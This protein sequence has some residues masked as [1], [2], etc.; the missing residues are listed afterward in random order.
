MITLR[1]LRYLQALAQHRH[2]GRAASACAVTQPALSMQ[3][4]DLER[5]LGATLV[6]RG[7]GE[8]KLTEIGEEI[9]RRSLRILSAV[10][11]LTEYALHRGRI[12]CG[13][14][15]LGVIPTLA[16]YLLPRILPPL[17]A[18]YPELRLELRE[19]QT[20]SLIA[21][22]ARGGL[23]AVVMA[24]PVED[25]DFETTALFEDRF[26]LAAPAAEG[27]PRRARIEAS[28]IDPRRLILLEDGHCLRDQALD[29][30]GIAGGESIKELAATSLATVMQMVANGYGVTLMPEIA[31]SVEAR[32]ERVT[33]LR[34]TAPEPG[35]TV[36]LA[37]RRTSSR[38]A[39]FLAL[40]ALVI[41]T[42]KH[43][44]RVAPMKSEAGQEGPLRRMR[45]ADTKRARAV[46]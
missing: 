28:A 46:K 10:S 17:Q 15:R 40:G 5:E 30:C 3:I 39:D 1:Q 25:A 32:D 6:E 26:L 45:K 14:L 23:D 35:R 22:L 8:A 36:G 12:L 4:R 24:L 42:M 41:D 33:L 7:A 20:K 13:P 18:R 29:F 38:R 2:F 19:S 44:A 43:P 37:W 27:H 21:E 16:P 31:A 11:D 9:V 34:F